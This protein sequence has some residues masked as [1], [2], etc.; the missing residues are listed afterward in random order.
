[1]I[2]FVYKYI[3]EIDTD[4]DSFFL[5]FLYFSLLEEEDGIFST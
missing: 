2:F 4:I 1:M 5:F 3:F